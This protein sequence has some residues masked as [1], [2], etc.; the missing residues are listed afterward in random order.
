[1]KTITINCT[2]TDMITIIVR[3]SSFSY[4]ALSTKTTH[5][6]ALFT[7][8]ALLCADLQRSVSLLRHWSAVL[9]PTK[10]SVE[11]K[12]SS[13]KSASLSPGTTST[14]L[15]CL[16]KKEATVDQIKHT[17]AHTTLKHTS[18]HT[19]LQTFFYTKHKQ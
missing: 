19:T 4:V 13:L 2:V 18:A 14:C 15:G 7:A 12:Y 10:G 5:I 1:M 3:L 8:N 6:L 16:D 9:Q 11:D 17:S